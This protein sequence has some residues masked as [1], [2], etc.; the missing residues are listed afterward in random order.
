MS[1]P[2]AF[3]CLIRARPYRA[4]L[5]MLICFVDRDEQ[6]TRQ[7]V[8]EKFFELDGQL[9]VDAAAAAPPAAVA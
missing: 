8:L 5:L 9:A 6:R 4:Y 7:A 2:A 3:P 1:N